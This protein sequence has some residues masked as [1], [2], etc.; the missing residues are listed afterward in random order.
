MRFPGLKLAKITGL[1][2][3]R[4]LMLFW[5]LFLQFKRLF[6]VKNTRKTS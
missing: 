5:S 2:I 1:D 6:L 3:L 4:T